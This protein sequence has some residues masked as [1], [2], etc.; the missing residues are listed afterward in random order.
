MRG[1]DVGDDAAKDQTRSELERIFACAHF[2]LP[3]PAT[4]TLRSVVTQ[5]T[6]FGRTVS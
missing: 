6:S 2:H 5:Q 3:R 1:L 4:A